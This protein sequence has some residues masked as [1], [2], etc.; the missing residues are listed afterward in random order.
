M[1]RGKLLLA[2]HQFGGRTRTGRTGLLQHAEHVMKSGVVEEPGW[3]RA[4]QLCA[5]QGGRADEA[6]D[7]EGRAR[8]TPRA[9]PPAR[10][11]RACPRR[12]A[13]RRA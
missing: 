8:L 9:C 13:G 4:V 6:S 10:R 11:R 12:R 3:L 1:T 7:S 2:L 5:E